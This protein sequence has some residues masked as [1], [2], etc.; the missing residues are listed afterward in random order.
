[1]SWLRFNLRNEIMMTLRVSSWM[2]MWLGCHHHRII[3][4]QEEKQ[5]WGKGL[6]WAMMSWVIDM[7]SMK[8][9]WAS[10]WKH[11]VGRWIHRSET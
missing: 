1:M 4:A 6:A 9:L 11:L 8:D 3:K 10:R 5:A 2:T 7:V